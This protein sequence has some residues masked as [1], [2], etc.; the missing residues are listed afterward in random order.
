VIEAK[1]KREENLTKNTFDSDDELPNDEDDD[2]EEA[3]QLWKIR[4]LGRLRRD[5]D[6][7]DREFLEKERTER[8]RMM[9]DEERAK[10]D[11]R[12]GKY[13]T[14]EKSSLQFMQK[15]YHTGIFGDRNDPLF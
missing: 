6:E 5:R 4:E 11:K 3:Y 13:K 12:I 10:D 9:T 15:F 8:R 14:T 2:P 7:R 1:S